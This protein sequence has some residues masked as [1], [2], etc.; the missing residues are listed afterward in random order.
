[1]PSRTPGILAAYV[2][3]AFVIGFGWFILAP[4]VPAIM[5][6]F[7]E[8]LG[9][10]LL[11]ISLYGYTMIVASLPAGLWTAKKGPKPVLWFAISLTIVGLFVRVLAS[12]YA[13]LFIGQVIAA[14]AY[15]FLIAPIGAV[16]RIAGVMRTKMATGLVI[17][18]L[19]LGMALASL[20]A[21][22]MTLSTN[23]GLTA[24]LAAM[25]GLWLAISVNQISPVSSATLG[26]VRIVISSWWW[27]GFI[28]AS[29][30]VMYGSISTT[31]LSHLHVPHAIFVGAYLSSLTFL[32]SAVGA[33]LFGWLGQLRENSMGLQRILAILSWLFLVISA[34]ELTG[35]L[36]VQVKGLA[37][38]FLAFGVVSNGWYTLALEASARQA[39]GPGS[40]GLATAGYS[41]ASNIGVAV[42]PVVLGPLVITSPYVWVLI[43]AVMGLVAVGVPFIAKTESSKILGGREAS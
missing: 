21:P 39:Q 25:V 23:F 37:L 13:E 35:I 5:A 17:G 7:H 6:R 22:S 27:I 28:V 19:F 36:L 30:S 2:A 42:V 14:V 11:L 18:C 38:S 24:L 15:P 40:A 4:M 29:M 43:I 26:P 31:A 9:S 33:A 1:M 20:L 16:L 41:M 32:G 3:F 34:L 8:P 12:N 10:V